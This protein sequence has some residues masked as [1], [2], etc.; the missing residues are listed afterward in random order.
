MVPSHESIKEVTNRGI[1]TK[2]YFLTQLSV[3]VSCLYHY[4]FNYKLSFKKNFFFTLI[5][6]WG[7]KNSKD[8]IYFFFL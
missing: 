7:E 5:T 2:P 6:R 3:L 1:G 4:F 8:R